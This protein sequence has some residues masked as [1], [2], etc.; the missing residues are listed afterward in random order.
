MKA[1]PGSVLICLGIPLS[2]IYL[3]K[4]SMTLRVV[5]ARKTFE[6]CHPVLLSID[7]IKYFLELF[8]VLSGPAKSMALSS[9]V[10]R[11]SVFCQ[12]FVFS[13]YGFY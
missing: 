7:T 2:A 12:K 10:L 9:F 6:S 5:G 4:N 1:V 3:C 11:G 13:Y 8:A